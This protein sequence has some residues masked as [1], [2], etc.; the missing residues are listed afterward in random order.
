MKKLVTLITAALA[1][2]FTRPVTM[3]N[4]GTAG[5]AGSGVPMSNG[6]FDFKAMVYNLLGITDGSPDADDMVNCRYKKAMEAEAEEEDKERAKKEQ[7]ANEKITALEAA[8]AAAE[9]KVKEQETLMANE[10][11]KVTQLEADLTTAKQT[12]GTVETQ[13]AN[14]RTAHIKTILD[15]A[16]TS[17]RITGAERAALELEFSKDFA[18]ANEKLSKKQSALPAGQVGPGALKQRQQATS[19]DSTK[20]RDA[21]IEACNEVMKADNCTYDAAFAKVQKTKPALF[22][23]MTVP[24]QPEHLKRKSA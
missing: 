6:T 13:F 14:E 15:H 1:M 18:A 4:E 12:I 7:A 24:E 8:K 23:G 21:V 17:N 2:V 16:V 22:E 20:R 19:A 9:A 3:A 5:G 11:S 10:A